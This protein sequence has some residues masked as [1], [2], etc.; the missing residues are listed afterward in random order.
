MAPRGPG[1]GERE[2]LD[3]RLIF[4]A[5][6]RSRL[7]DLQGGQRR[8][9]SIQFTYRTLGDWQDGRARIMVYGVR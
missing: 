8:I 3:T 6:S 9:R 2:R 1:N 7:L 5:G 4:D